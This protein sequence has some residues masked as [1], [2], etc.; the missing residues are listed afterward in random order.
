MNVNTILNMITSYPSFPPLLSFLIIFIKYSNYF[1]IKPYPTRGH[2]GGFA[3]SGKGGVAACASA[4]G[5]VA[6]SRH[7]G[8]KIIF[9]FAFYPVIKI[10]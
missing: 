5:V 4:I 7:I 1:K 9:M 10:R 3:S 8:E 2:P 6:N